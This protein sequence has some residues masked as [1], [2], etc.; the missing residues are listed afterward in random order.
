MKKYFFLPI[1][2]ITFSSAVNSQ[3]ALQKDKE[4]SINIGAASTMIENYN[5]THDK[6]LIVNNKLGT[7]FSVQYSKYFSEKIG[8]GMG[9]GFS[10]YD[11]VYYQKGLFKQVNQVDKDGRIYDKWIN[12][13]VK[14]SN[15][16]LYAEI[17]VIAHFLIGNS[18][19]CYGFIDA[20]II[21]QFLTRGTHTENG[22][23]ETMGK[24]GSETGNP[25]W[26][27]VTTD[28]DYYGIGTTE[29]S[30][31]EK[32]KFESYNL[33]GH[34][35]IGLAAIM[36]KGLYLKVNP[37]A[38][39]G[40]LDITSKEGKGKEY[41]NILGEQSSYKPTRLFSAGINVGLALDL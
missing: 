33:S 10:N 5:I 11:Q 31:K 6:N 23:I 20:G 30:V 34:L 8:V 3:V 26:F 40:V 29:V 19:R 24:Y 39:A 28:N 15:K 14:F 38:N 1:I 27:G 32:N 22:T 12:S 9:I 13:D 35:G 21:N 16:L 7:D 2:F 37:Y 4:I 18:S 41:E 36:T 25:D 17:P